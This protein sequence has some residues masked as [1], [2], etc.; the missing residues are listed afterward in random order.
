LNIFCATWLEF[1]D[2][3][4]LCDDLFGTI[5]N[6]IR[7]ICT[8]FNSM[9]LWLFVICGQLL[10]IYNRK[11]AQNLMDILP[12][13]KVIRKESKEIIAIW[14]ILSEFKLLFDVRGRLFHD[15][16]FILMGNVLL[17]VNLI[18]SC[19]Y[20]FI[21]FL[22]TAWVGIFW[23]VS[24]VIEFISRFWLICHTADRIRSSV[25]RIIIFFSIFI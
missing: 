23:E 17:N 7:L 8:L 2:C 21:E 9:A 20:Y 16:R 10:V 6:I 5:Q 14:S 1:G 24:V 22:D 18:L 11:I 19:S 15:Y 3:W 13:Q 12:R 4:P 25:S